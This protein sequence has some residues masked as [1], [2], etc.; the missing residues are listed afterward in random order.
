MK[1]IHFACLGMAGALLAGSVFLGNIARAG[2]I[3]DL[4]NATIVEDFLFDDDA[5]TAYDAAA[6]NAGT[7]HLI[8]TDSDLDGVT[9]NGSGALNAS[10]KNNTGLG[11]PNVDNDD[12]T[13]GR[14][15]GVMEMTWNFTSTLDAAENEELRI[16][17]LNA[18]TSTVTAEFEIERNDD[19]QLEIFGT[20]VGTGS[21][22]IPAAILNG[23]SLVQS[24]KFIAVVDAN[25]D[26]DEYFVH[27][28]SDAGASFTTI[29]PGTI[30][31]ARIGEKLRM[32][33]NNDFVGDNVLI[34][35][36][37]LATIV[38]EPSSMLLL[39]LGCGLLAGRRGKSA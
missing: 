14:V 33:I 12:I 2:I 19:D 34:D 16:S 10:L 9:T 29:G 35:R 39:A 28:S 24:T 18:G 13:F 1:C 36:V 21:S 31:A 22:N 4:A 3:E 5:G 25:L 37:Y 23:G 26:T 11:S 32:V 6:N 27:Y 17:I 7:G 15:F 30:D 8:S 38:P 20:A